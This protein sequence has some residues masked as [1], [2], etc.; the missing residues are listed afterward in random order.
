MTTP[1]CGKCTVC[2][3]TLMVP[4][5]NK[6]AG[7]RCEHL[8]SQGCGIYDQRPDSCRVFDCGWKRFSSRQG[9]NI[10]PKLRPDRAGFMI[11]IQ[12]KIPLSKLGTRPV[13][14]D[15]KFNQNG[16]GVLALFKNVGGTVNAVAKRKAKKLAQKLGVPTVMRSTARSSSSH[17]R[18]TRHPAPFRNPSQAVLR[19]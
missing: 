11:Y 14:Q 2:C 15:I 5:L 7:V 17:R 12:N 19:G 8:T 18:R 4:E 3:T 6:P 10:T 16:D 1:N 13:D 9:V